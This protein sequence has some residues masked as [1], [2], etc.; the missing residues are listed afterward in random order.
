MNGC[1][2]FC[3]S[4]LTLCLPRGLY[5][6]VMTS[7]AQDTSTEMLIC[8]ASSLLKAS[9]W[10][11]SLCCILLPPLSPIASHLLVQSEQIV[12]FHLTL[13]CCSSV[14]LG[15]QTLSFALPLQGPE[16][17]PNQLVKC[18]MKREYDSTR[19]KAVKYSLRL[20]DRIG[21]STFMMTALQVSR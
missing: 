1:I 9:L 7:S 15:H 3:H 14:S 19:P 12:R 17:L 16:G 6:A 18:V 2:L 21:Q 10:A 8:H 4:T 20:G 11:W 13:M 5:Y